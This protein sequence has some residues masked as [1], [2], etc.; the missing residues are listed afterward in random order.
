[1]LSGKLARLIEDH[2]EQIAKA[3][4]RAISGNP[5][6]KHLSS[7]SDS[8]LLESW[9]EILAKLTRW[10]EPSQREALGREHEEAGRL[11]LEQG[12]P[13]HESVLALQLVRNQTVEYVA[14]QELDRNYIE[15][16]AEEEL[17]RWLANFFDFLIYHLVKGYEAAL[18]EKAGLEFKQ[19]Q[20]PRAKMLW[21]P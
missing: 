3:A 14:Q 5:N 18:R 16:Y 12:I 4:I 2:S 8:R 17:E 6:L 19:R 1:M 9:T 11:R 15:L 20:A 21:V 10:L 13:L 7:L